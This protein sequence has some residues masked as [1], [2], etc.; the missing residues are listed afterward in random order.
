MSAYPPSPPAP[1][2]APS[3]AASTACYS[4]AF[5]LIHL[6]SSFIRCYGKANPSWNGEKGLKAVQL[7]V[8]MY[9]NELLFLFQFDPHLQSGFDTNVLNEM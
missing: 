1:P 9:R 7:G 3:P 5:Q 2:P 8:P 6:F 4:T